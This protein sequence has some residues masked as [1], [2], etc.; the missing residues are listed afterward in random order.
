VEATSKASAYLTPKMEEMV[1]LSR[2]TGSS[3]KQEQPV[4]QAKV[5]EV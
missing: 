4:K 5:E 1:D 2:E 3:G